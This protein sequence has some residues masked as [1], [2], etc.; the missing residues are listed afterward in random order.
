LMP[1]SVWAGEWS[2]ERSS[3]HGIIWL[4][5]SVSCIRFVFCQFFQWLSVWRM[6]SRPGGGLDRVFVVY[7][8]TWVRVRAG[9]YYLVYMLS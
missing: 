2:F 7:V 1:S 3:G 9:C 5:S 4:L 8:I 6:W